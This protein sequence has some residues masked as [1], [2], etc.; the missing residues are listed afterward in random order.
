MSNV[1]LIITANK[2]PNGDAGAIR[3]HSF[4]K[5]FQK[6]GYKP[7]VI[8]IGDSTHFKEAIYDGIQYYSVRY[9]NNNVVYRVLGRV[10]FLHN[11][12]KILKQFLPEQIKGILVVSG[13][14]KV[15]EY[16]KQFS[17]KHEI[18]IYHDSVEWYSPGEFRKG[19]RD[20]SY[21]VN[22]ELNTKIIDKNYKVFAISRYL[23]QAFQKRG[24]Q[25]M[26]IP[27][28]MDVQQMSCNKNMAKEG[29]IRIVYA[30]QVGGKDHLSEIVQAIESLGTAEIS[31]IQL[32]F[33]GITKEQY[34][35]KFQAVREDLMGES[36]CF[37]G[38]IKRED[39]LK[40]LQSAHFTV[41][42]RPENERY[43]KAGFPTKV[44]E[45]LCTA[46]PVICNYTS[47]LNLYLKDGYNAI[48]LK[49][50]SWKACKK[51]LEKLLLLSE[52]ELKNMQ[53]NARK[54]AEE[55]FDWRL[56]VEPVEKF[57]NQ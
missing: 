28:I 48:V 22:N 17:Q 12:R 8:G 46:T 51:G 2:Y 40:E 36:I 30:G 56:Y 13:G 54:S 33:I 41:L 37:M 19:V 20:H 24:I 9:A 11:T 47:D 52:N 23:E 4:A 43:A 29:R 6:L 27:V 42:V 44:V 14:K 3:Q 50:C 18:P 7:V 49:E 32:R 53:Q 45:S 55:N 15:F 31:R 38:H 26:R 1:F 39:V 10:L 25:T 57:V 21:K 16:V 34:E 5:I 35:K